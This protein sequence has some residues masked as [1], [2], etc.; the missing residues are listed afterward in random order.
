MAR[1][2]TKYNVSGVG[3]NLNKR[4]LVGNVV[5]H[6][7]AANK[8]T[9]DE[10]SNQFPDSIQGSKGFIRKVKDVDDPKR[11]DLKNPIVLKYKVEACVSNQWGKENVAAFVEHIKGLG[12]AV[13]EVSAPS[14]EPAGSGDSS[15]GFIVPGVAAPAPDEVVMP[16]VSDEVRAL[17]NEAGYYEMDGILAQ[18]LGK[19]EES[20]TCLDFMPFLM[21]MIAENRF[22]GEEMSEDYFGQELQ[23][24]FVNEKMSEIIA[25][26]DDGA[27]GFGSV[28]E[29]KKV[30][31]DLLKVASDP[32][33]AVNFECHMQITNC[34]DQS[35]CPFENE[36]DMHA[37]AD[38]HLKLAA[39]AADGMYELTE[40][41]N[42][43]GTGENELNYKND[44]L[45]EECINRGLEL[46]ESFDDYRKLCFKDEYQLAKGDQF[47]AALAGCKKCM[48]ADDFDV[49]YWVDEIKEMN[50][51]LER[52]GMA[53][54][55]IPD[56]NIEQLR[57]MK[58]PE[59]LTPEWDLSWGSFANIRLLN[60]PDLESDGFTIHL[61]LATGHI[62]G[63][64]KENEYSEREYRWFD[65]EAL[66]YQYNQEEYASTAHI[67]LFD[68]SHLMLCDVSWHDSY[69]DCD[70]GE[71][72]ATLSEERFNEI[73]NGKWFSALYHH[74]KHN[75]GYDGMEEVSSPAQ[76]KKKCFS[77]GLESGP[78]Y[79]LRTSAFTPKDGYMEIVEDFN[80]RFESDDSETQ[81]LQITEDGGSIFIIAS[82]FR[83]KMSHDELD[84]HDMC[85]EEFDEYLDE[86]GIVDAALPAV[87]SMWESEEWNVSSILEA[88]AQPA[89]S[90]HV[91]LTD[92]EY[93]NSEYDLST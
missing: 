63:C 24:E 22:C 19:E 55:E 92:T 4:Q 77:F 18:I 21:G 48:E 91:Q 70:D 83:L 49:E 57:K 44:A 2:Y 51:G 54:F 36:S 42:A 30:W 32:A 71:L 72:P 35:I 26:A 81:F 90:I 53:T 11:F 13:E 16:E 12:Y 10:L 15:T 45:L 37:L 41:I 25:E 50:D 23:I 79:Q 85:E 7:A 65:G 84:P 8:P 80:Q 20:V 58:L 59:H 82:T 86:L 43:C 28:S 66:L 29:Y 60:S 9:F 34:I 87:K 64:K 93:G 75:S 46:A 78:T 61:S 31:S 1:D 56:Y 38:K 89:Q 67:Q 74:I 68:R 52:L 69:E 88:L 3:Q 73:F 14:A 76:V 17:I 5:R 40:V 6:W 33:V 47:E 62:L 27:A 39:E